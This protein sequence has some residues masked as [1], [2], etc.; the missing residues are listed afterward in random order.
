MANTVLDSLAQSNTDFNLVQSSKEVS[1]DIL[2][3]ELFTAL[4]DYGVINTKGGE[5]VGDTVNFYNLNR[6]DSNGLAET[7]DAYSNAASSIHGHRQIIMDTASYSHKAKK[8]NTMAAIRAET[9][10]GK[11]DDGIL[12]IMSSWGKS[13]LRAGLINQLA[14]NNATSISVPAASTTA[15]SGTSLTRVT[16]FNSV[17]AVNSLYNKFGNNAAGGVTTAAGITNANTLTLIDFMMLSDIVFDVY[18]GVT[19]WNPLDSMG[20]AQCRALAVVTRTGWTQLMTSVPAAGNYPSVAFELYN[21]IAAG[22]G[23]KE[24][25]TG[26]TIGNYRIYKSAFTPDIDYLVVDDHLL[27]QAVHSNA[28]QANTKVA[29][30]LGRNA[31]DMKVSKLVKSGSGIP[32]MIEEDNQHEKLNNFDYWKLNMKF[33]LKRT[34]L[35][36]TGANAST[37]YDYATAVINHYSAK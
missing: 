12:E 21:A 26:R 13:I 25:Y 24:E 20:K 37:D 6:V 33:G 5:T 27:P 22:G 7:D 35:K 2:S 17:T 18:P 15:F 31:V 8:K 16:G 9:S 30:L 1:K 36:G 11:L 14:G 34:L 3:D 28:A 4:R 29:L 32:F 19:P 10:V 23:K